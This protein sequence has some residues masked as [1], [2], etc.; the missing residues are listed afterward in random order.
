MMGAGCVT[1]VNA[2]AGTAG[3]TD[4]SAAATGEADGRVGATVGPAGAPAGRERGG[5]GTGIVVKRAKGTR[6]G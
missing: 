6:R 4:V 2:V 3:M 5:N 1:A